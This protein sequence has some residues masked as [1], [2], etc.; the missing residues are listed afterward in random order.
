M[1]TTWFLILI[2]LLSLFFLIKNK[3]KNNRLPPGPP[4]IPIIGNLLWLCHPLSDLESVLRDVHAKYGPIITLRAGSRLMIFIS[5]RRL[6]HTALITHGA[7]FAGR[8][9]VTAHGKILTANSHNISGSSYGPLWR[10]LR[11]NMVREALHPSL[12]QLFSPTRKWVLGVLVEKLKKCDNTKGNSIM[13]CFQFGMFSLLVYMC[14]G[15]RLDE[16][17]VKAIESALRDLLLYGNKLSVFA[18]VPSVTKYLFRNRWN[19]V[20]KLAEKRKEICMPLIK[21][22]KGL[23]TKNGGIEKERN[24]G[25][26]THCYVDTLLDL[27]HTEEGG[28]SLSDDELIVLCGEFLNA[29]TDTTS[30]ALQWIMAELVKNPNVQLK[31]REEIKQVLNTNNGCDEVKEEYLEK[32]PYLKAVVLEGLRRHP[33]AHFVLYHAVTEEITINGYIIPENA[34]V[35]FAVAEI[36]MNK[37]AWE[38]PDEFKPERFLEGGEGDKLDI[39]GTKEIK[40]M[41]FGVGRRICAGLGVAML[42]LEY[43]VANLVKEFEWK[44]IEGEEIDLDEKIE[45]TT[46]MKNPLKA[47]LVPRTNIHV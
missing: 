11:R 31:L 4:S 22:R 21:S 38:N 34:W 19:M 14:F 15:E 32:M 1:E 46:V 47:R 43:F 37:E 41:P 30:T 16:S 28:R 3:R 10:L 24:K 40:M 13:E 44:E 42:H 25:V 18:F 36:G 9:A 26:L 33:P 27:K 17:Y 2:F 23:K 6:A 35:N 7:T 45:F 8:P 12:V 5:D 39:T 20:M 29:G